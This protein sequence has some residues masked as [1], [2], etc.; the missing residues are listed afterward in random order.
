MPSLALHPLTY[1]QFRAFQVPS[2][3][4][5][6]LL[7]DETTEKSCWLMEGCLFIWNG[8]PVG[9]E[10]KNQCRKLQAKLDIFHTAYAPFAQ[11]QE[12]SDY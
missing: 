1:M 6:Y 8:I 9:G 2:L 5:V 4:S 7:C 10:K 3:Y 12:Q 11:F